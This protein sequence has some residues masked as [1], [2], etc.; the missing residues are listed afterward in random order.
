MIHPKEG[1]HEKSD[2]S[3]DKVGDLLEQIGCQLGIGNSGNIRNFEIQHEQRESNCVY[4][5]RDRA[6]PVRCVRAFQKEMHDSHTQPSGRG[7][8]VCGI[9]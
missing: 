7:N 3:G 1:D 2:D 6:Q 9:F 8:T 5:V 4:A